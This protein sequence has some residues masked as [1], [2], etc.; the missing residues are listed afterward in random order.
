MM[1]ISQTVNYSVD[2][3]EV[4][5]EANGEMLDLPLIITVLDGRCPPSGWYI[6]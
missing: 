3:V 2:A 4:C 6:L 5:N 1:E